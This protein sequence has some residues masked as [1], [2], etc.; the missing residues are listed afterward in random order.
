MS[1]ID[2]R[3]LG[4]LLLLGALW[5]S[6]YALSRY[7]ITHGVPP[8]GYACWQS[9]G[10]ACLLALYSFLTRK[11]NDDPFSQYHFVFFLGLCGIAIPNTNMYFCLQHLPAG[12][13]AIIDN[14]APIFIYIIAI[15]LGDESFSLNR[16]CCVFSAVVGVLLIVA[17]RHSAMGQYPLRWLLQA[18]V[19]PLFFGFVAVC[20]AKRCQG[21]STRLMATGMLMTSSLWL[22]PLTLIHHQFY[23]P[24]A[25]WQMRD[26]VVL[27]EIVFS[28][29]GYLIFFAL[30]KRSGSVYYS[31]VGG[32]VAIVGVVL[33]NLFFNELINWR[34]V[35][36]MVLIIGSTW[37]IT[38]LNVQ[39]TG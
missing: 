18:F 12:L 2:I 26:T 23:L 35:F 33:G 38:R 24:V 22:V 39:R 25:S 6:G 36:G 9:M 31:F 20:I 3:M 13:M 29:L 28:S 21:V 32:V 7:A 8:L 11:Q 14:M 19:S 1:R 5:G 10:P 34:M 16:L 30:L 4:L 27:L 17:V 37:L 15:T